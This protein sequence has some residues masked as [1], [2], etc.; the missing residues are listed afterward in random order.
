MK[1]KVQN[2]FKNRS[3]WWWISNTFFW[4]LI[5]AV[6]IPQTRNYIRQAVVFVFNSNP[7][8]NLEEDITLSNLTLV[9]MR[10]ELTE[11]IPSDKP[12]FVN[13]WATWCGPCRSEMP[14]LQVF[15]DKFK[16]KVDFYFIAINDHPSRVANYLKTNDFQFPV[17]FSARGNERNLIYGLSN[18][19]PTSYIIDRNGKIVWQHIGPANYASN[20][21]AETME[22]FIED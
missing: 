18:S 6:A 21:F 13:M 11:A 1:N 8:N 22:S 2:Y 20:A 19:I 3:K 15:Y 17:H 12:I 4:L 7:G 9:N 14:S 5:I 16:D 10:G